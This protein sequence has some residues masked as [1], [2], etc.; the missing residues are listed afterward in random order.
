[1]AAPP[2]L[3]VNLNNTWTKVAPWNGGKIGR[4]ERVKTSELNLSQVRQW[5]KRFSHSPLCLASVVPEAEKYVE[6]IYPPEQCH[7]ITH[8]SPLGFPISF[9]KPA[10][11]GADRLANAAAV[12]AHYR[13]PAVVLDFGTALTFDVIDTDGSYR[14]GVIAPGLGVFTDYLA[15]RTALLPRLTLQPPAS[16]I[17][18]S[19]HHA[20]RSGAYFGYCGL[21]REILAGIKKELNSRQLTVIATGGHSTLLSPSIPEI[22]HL[23]PQLTM[24]GIAHIARNWQVGQT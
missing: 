13:Y 22:K 16:V 24:K 10:T 14:G 23:D 15:E 12:H 7:R 18:T 21:I 11:V 3:L 19:T 20:M 8:R 5:K 6:R 17:G 1:M 4:I 9:P 2:L